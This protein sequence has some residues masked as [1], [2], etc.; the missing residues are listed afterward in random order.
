MFQDKVT[1]LQE[2]VQKI[3]WSKTIGQFHI[4]I[5]WAAEYCSNE[6]RNKFAL[7]FI[8]INCLQ[9][10]HVLKMTTLWL[11]ACCLASAHWQY[12][13]GM[14]CFISYSINSFNYLLYHL[15]P[16]FFPH[17]CYSAS[18]TSSLHNS[19]SREGHTVLK[20][21][22]AGHRDMCWGQWEQRKIFY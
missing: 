18:Y 6:C 5:E 4:D 13:L 7:S 20:N 8:N 14:F 12:P 19:E 10:N 22:P 9:P 16:F 1:S 21:V 3:I 17:Y 15:L 2:Y 11:H